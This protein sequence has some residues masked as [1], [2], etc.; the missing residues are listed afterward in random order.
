MQR[1]A[2]ILLVCCVVFSGCS[3]LRQREKSVRVGSANELSS[4][5]VLGSAADVNEHDL[6][7]QAAKA[8]ADKGHAN[9][10]IKLYEKAESLA[11]QKTNLDR[12]LAPLYA[13]VGKTDA[14]IARY[15]K[16]IANGEAD[17]EH[18]NNLA[19]TLMESGQLDKATETIQQGLMQSPNNERL[20]ATQAVVFYKQGDRN[21]SF[22]AFQ[23]LY[24]QSAAHHNLAILDLDHGNKDAAL[25]H[26]NTATELADCP[27]QTIAL[28]EAVESELRLAA[29]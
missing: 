23:K 17:A 28:K 24:G 22:Q 11:P 21:Q 3:L 4:L 14:A 29:R 26:L 1:T 18:F 19:W 12:P 6:C 15:R 2:G 27:E 9:E 8:V 10:A 13:S 5:P 16:V 25:Q 20:Q 7:I